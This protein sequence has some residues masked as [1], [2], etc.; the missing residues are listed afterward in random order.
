MK[1]SVG[2]TFVNTDDSKN[3][4]CV[5]VFDNDNSITVKSTGIK[6]CE[7]LAKLLAAAPELLEALTNLK[8]E[9]VKECNI[10]S[11]KSLLPMLGYVQ[12]AIRAI[13]KATE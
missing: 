2:R 3:K 12:D 6:D 11:D 4:Q 7:K 13:K 8:D 1:T 10:G 9:V 5:V